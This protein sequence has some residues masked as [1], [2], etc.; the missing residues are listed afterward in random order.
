MP[1]DESIKMWKY[2]EARIDHTEAKKSQKTQRQTNKQN[3][4]LQM[5]SKYLMECKKQ[6]KWQSNSRKKE[7]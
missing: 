5:H 4:N 1:T 6:K 2:I 3:Q 7:Y